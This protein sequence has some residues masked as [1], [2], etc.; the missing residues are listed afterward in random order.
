[1][2][3]QEIKTE[4]T[5]L[6]LWEYVPMGEYQIPEASMGHA[7]RGG[8]VGLWQR[9]RPAPE[10]AADLLRSEEALQALPKTTLDRI[11]PEPSWRSAA[12]ALKAKLIPWINEEQKEKRG[13]CVIAPPNGNNTNVLIQLADDLG[14]PVISPPTE[15][16]IL[17]QDRGWL[18]QWTGR[19]E[20]WILPEL[21]RCYL[22][23]ARGL[24]LVRSFFDKL[25]SGLLGRGI[26]GC[27]SWAW[28]YLKYVT[29]GALPNAYVAQAFDHE[30][31]ALWFQ[32][33][34]TSAKNKRIQFRQSDD[35][36]YV[37]PPKA[38]SVNPSDPTVEIGRFLQHLAAHSLGISGVAWFLWRSALRT[39][40]DEAVIREGGRETPVDLKTTVWVLPWDQLNQP[41]LPV[42]MKTE[43]ALVLHNLLL[44]SGLSSIALLEVVPLSSGSALQ[45]LS[46]LE[47]M[48]FIE[49]KKGIWR[50]SAQGYPAV[51]RALHGEG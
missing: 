12:M 36:T 22:R 25:E 10:R 14:C 6:S 20:F 5:S 23:H 16:E 40:P 17:G 3:G 38:D 50:V 43:D 8:I 2:A 32:E 47:E 37:L 44:H 45:T 41:T 4:E 39:L 1:M 29:Y 19:E 18:N 35:E 13:V 42:P 31:L 15:D 27:D 24:D 33:L 30:R 34:S 28:A 48:G 26:I 49:Q 11:A 21:E 46:A 7:I 9:F 51:R